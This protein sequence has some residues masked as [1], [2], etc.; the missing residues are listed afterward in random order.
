MLY[1][2]L[3]NTFLGLTLSTFESIITSDHVYNVEC[4]HVYM[5]GLVY[6]SSEDKYLSY[7]QRTLGLSEKPRTSVGSSVY[8]WI[9]CVVASSKI[10]QNF[11]AGP[12]YD[13]E[14]PMGLKI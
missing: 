13:G 8:Y 7:D 1:T 3:Y 10:I 4:V 2:T 5:Y 6:R 14:L 9:I 11:G 12:R